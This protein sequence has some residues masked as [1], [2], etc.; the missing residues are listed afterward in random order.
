M[1][2]LEVN[3][4]IVEETLRVKIKNALGGLKLEPVS[5]NLADFDGVLYH[6][7]TPN[8]SDRSKIVT[9]ISLKFY[10]E[11]QTHG[12]DELLRR[13]YGPMLLPKA[14]E[15]YDVSVKINLSAIPGDWEESWVTKIGRLK[16]NCF[17][18]VFER[19]FVYQEDMAAKEEAGETVVESEH[20]TVSSTTNRP[21]R[22]KRKLTLDFFCR[23]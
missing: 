20:K 10:K 23:Q 4:R 7:S 14:E 9:S 22:Q 2:L 18:S 16:R 11:L 19:Y 13:V 15:G 21:L 5:V 1:I 8:N 17:A 6:I 3:N 12:T